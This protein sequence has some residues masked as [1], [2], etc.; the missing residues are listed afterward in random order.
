SVLCQPA[1]S[2]PRNLA[3]HVLL[4]LAAGQGVLDAKF[5]LSKSDIPKKTG[6]V[7]PA[8]LV[9]LVAVA[10]E[11]APELVRRLEQEEPAVAAPVGAAEAEALC[12]AWRADAASTTDRPD[13][14]FSLPNKVK[15]AERLEAHASGGTSI[16]GGSKIYIK[17]KLVKGLSGIGCT[18][19]EQGVIT[20]IDPNGTVASKGELAVGDQIVEINR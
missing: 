7:P 16:L 18:I 11:C 10:R 13:S 9:R 8:A 4:L 3:E 5:D 15:K 2:L 17:S 20:E 6:P 12:N 1:G 14:K 19:S